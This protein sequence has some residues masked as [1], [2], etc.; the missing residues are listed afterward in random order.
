MS[1]KRKKKKKG[2][3][4]IVLLSLLI[5][6]CVICLRTLVRD[7]LA[8]GIKS[9]VAGKVTETVMEQAIQKAL[10]S[11]GDPEAAARA[12]EIVADMDEADKKEA[13]AIVEKYANEETVSALKDMMEGGINSE[14]VSQAVDYLQDNVSEED[15]RKLQEL[16]EKY[17][18]EVPRD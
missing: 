6:A 8:E 18:A 5:V 1:K 16:Y 7:S 14:S 11:S 10:K 2:V 13:E 3:G 17:G 12:K 9:A 4:T 15:I